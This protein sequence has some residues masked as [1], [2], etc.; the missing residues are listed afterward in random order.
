MIDT[1]WN[2]GA[3]A[4]GSKV[5]ALEVGDVMV[6]ALAPGPM[7]S[8]VSPIVIVVASVIVGQV[9]A[10]LIRSAP[11]FALAL[12]TAWRREPAPVSAQLVTVYVAACA[13][14]AN[15]IESPAAI[16]V[17]RVDRAAAV[18]QERRA[19]EKIFENGIRNLVKKGAHLI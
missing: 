17:P 8:T 18:R 3:D 9:K 2:A 4:I 19:D 10:K 11:G 1:S 13:G 5:S 12:S 7:M 14:Q 16:E 6:R 15:K